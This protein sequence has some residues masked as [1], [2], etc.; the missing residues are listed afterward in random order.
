MK[1][2]V[3]LVVYNAEEYL[4]ECMRS[5]LCQTFS[6]FELLIIDDGSTDNSLNVIKKFQDGRTRLILNKHDY[7]NSLNLGLRES[8]GEYIARMDADDIMYPHRLEKQVAILDSHPEVA[9][10]MSWARTFGLVETELR[11]GNGLVMDA[12]AELL[13]ANFLIHPTAMLRK[14][15][16][17]SQKLQYKNY[18]YA[19]DYKLW[20]DMALG[21]SH[22][23]VIPECLLKYRVSHTQV[24]KKHTKEQGNTAVRIRNEILLA[25]LNDEQ[26]EQIAY[27]QDIYFNLERLNANGVLTSSSIREIMYI[28]FKET[29]MRTWK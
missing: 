26:N 21:G 20:T 8:Q 7:I 12:L 4:E 2:T 19:E 14:S 28:L 13:H 9:A 1:V 24:S 10:C 11:K 27:L 5:I 15:F 23:W 22:F 6:D 3:L 16:L 25:L 17:A 29:R 18:P